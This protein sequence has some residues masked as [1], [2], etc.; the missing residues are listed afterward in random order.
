[1]RVGVGAWGRYL[2]RAATDGCLGSHTCGLRIWG[3]GK[4]RRMHSLPPNPNAQVIYSTIP[5]LGFIY[6]W[7]S[8]PVVYISWDM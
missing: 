1:M 7:V 3:C 6:L 5:C 8:I 4:R 2:G